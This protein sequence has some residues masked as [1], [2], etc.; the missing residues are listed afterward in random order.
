MQ[1]ASRNGKGKVRGHRE[2][3]RWCTYI[4]CRMR[5]AVVDDENIVDEELC[6]LVGAKPKVVGTSFRGLIVGL[7][8]GSEK[9][10]KGQCVAVGVEPCERCGKQVI[11][12]GGFWIE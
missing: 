6:S 11:G 5:S 1:P 2:A 4:V 8:G 12:G 9:V 10:A 7:V 3:G